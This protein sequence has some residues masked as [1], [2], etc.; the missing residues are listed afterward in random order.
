MITGEDIKRL[1][2]AVGTDKA[3]NHMLTLLE[4][5]MDSLQRE[6]RIYVLQA[7]DTVVDTLGQ[8]P[9]HSYSDFQLTRLY[10]LKSRCHNQLAIVSHYDCR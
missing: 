1:F 9:A 4:T 5:T 3:I 2:A 8:D 10:A 6:S 7:F